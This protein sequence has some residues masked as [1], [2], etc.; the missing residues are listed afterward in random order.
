MITITL[1]CYSDINKE[2]IK[3]LESLHETNKDVDNTNMS[4]TSK[5]KF[6]SD[7]IKKVYQIF[8]CFIKEFNT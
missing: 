4:P 8:N 7:R 6:L 2:I 1:Y 5:K 3:L